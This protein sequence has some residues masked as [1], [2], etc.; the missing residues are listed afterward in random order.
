MDSG[1]LKLKRIRSRGNLAEKAHTRLKEAIIGGDIAPGCLLMEHQVT[2][3]LSISRTPVREA[4][5][6]LSMEGLVQAEPHKGVRVAALSPEDLAEL[7]EARESI[8]TR[9]L[10]RSAKALAQADFKRLREALQKA[11]EALEAARTPAEIEAAGLAYLKADRSMHD[12]LVKACGNRVWIGIYLN[13]RE[14]IEIV[15][16]LVGTRPAK[17]SL[18]VAQ[19]LNVLDALQIEDYAGAAELMLKHIRDSRDLALDILRRG[20]EGAP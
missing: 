5:N 2:K 12:E 6:R 9:F 17:L 15:G 4:F 19:H 14:R 13:I 1:P 16:R 10:E 3:A 20:E 7:F 11:G 8:E 18:T